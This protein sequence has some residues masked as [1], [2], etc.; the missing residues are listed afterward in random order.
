MAKRT[1][2]NQLRLMEFLK[3]NGSE[4]YTVKALAEKLGLPYSIVFQSVRSLKTRG[5]LQFENGA[6][7]TVGSAPTTQ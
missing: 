1:G 7:S 2:K 4:T 3:Q 6:V 5:E